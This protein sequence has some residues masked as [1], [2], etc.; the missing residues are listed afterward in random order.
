[1]DKNQ[2]QGLFFV[3][4]AAIGYS[5]LPT[6]T[7]MIY[8]NAESFQ[9]IDIAIWRFLFATPVIWLVIAARNQPLPDKPLPIKQLFGLGFIYSI[10]A[11]S[12]FFGLQRIPASLYIVLFYTYPAMVTVISVVFFKVRLSLLAWLALAMTLS[13]IALT[14]PDFTQLGDGDL[15][16]ILI[17]F[18]NALAVAVYYSL[19]GVVMKG[20]QAVTRGSAWVMTGTMIILSS[21]ILI[22]GLAIPD[23]LIAWLSL[24]GLA[25][26]STAMPISM[27]NIGISKLG[28][29][30]ASI[31]SAGEPVISL[32]WAMTLLDETIL[33]IQWVGA[34]LIVI[35][36]VLF[37]LRPTHRKSLATS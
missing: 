8:S 12:A 16:G 2:L 23:N 21:F 37:Q 24:L 25:I 28:A 11:V 14:V 13:G 22:R 30:H 17:A 10:A 29:T 5:L 1:M 31:I 18:V 26:V 4:S 3:S 33:P 35:S 34:A 6:F 36:V 9:A 27:L 7:K 15:L 20:H 32:F 19:I